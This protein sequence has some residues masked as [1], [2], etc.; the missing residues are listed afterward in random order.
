MTAPAAA[1]AAPEDLGVLVRREVRPRW[2]FR[3]PPFGG[4][5]GVARFEGGVLRRLL[6]VEEE[7]VLVAVAQPASERV[8]FAARAGSRAAAEHGIARMRFALGVDDDLRPFHER[9]RWDPMI[10]PAVRRQP[11]RRVRRRPEPFEALAWA[12]TE[13]LIEFSRAAEIQRRLVGRLGRRCPHTGLRD[14]PAPARL[15][16]VAP[17]WLQALDLSAGRAL[18]LIRA[19]RE[20][21]A[22]RIDLHGAAHERAWRRL[23]AISGIGRWTVEMLALHGQGRYDQVP[24][25]DLHLLEA[26]GRLRTGNPFARASEEEVRELLAPYHPWGGLAAG[27]LLSS[28]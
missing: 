5:D 17:A 6:H 26:V 12:I 11:G 28:P 1:V 21:A 24:A 4:P 7:P 18:A 22:G 16:G 2:V 13:Q 23:R 3:L 27:Y 9:F 8:A 19:A 25:G 14:V 15:A 10:G 20:V